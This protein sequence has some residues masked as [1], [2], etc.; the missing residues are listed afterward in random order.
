MSMPSLIFTASPD[1]ITPDL[2]RNGPP[3]PHFTCDAFDDIKAATLATLCL[4]E[5]IDD[6]DAVVARAPDYTT[7]AS[8][9][10]PWIYQLPSVIIEHLST[11]DNAGRTEI[12]AAWAGTEEWDIP[13]DELNEFQAWFLEL[14]TFL[15]R[16][17]SQPVWVWVSL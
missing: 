11:L 7:Q 5:D 17:P 10:G 1:K 13:D 3:P 2:A 9:D 6:I 15:S 12:A 8:S 4:G 16:T 14:C